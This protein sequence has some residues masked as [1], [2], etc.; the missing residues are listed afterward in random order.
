[1]NNNIYN[2]PFSDEFFRDCAA[3][4][5]YIKLDRM[6]DESWQRITSDKPLDWFFGN[7]NK[8]TS[9]QLALVKHQFRNED[10][11]WTADSHLE[12]NV[13]LRESRYTYLLT[14]EMNTDF[15][16]YFSDKYNLI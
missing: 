4:A 3:H 1:M 14:M 13:E 16:A 9:S 15:L 6:H 12:L 10:E 5:V 7:V 2:T 11:R 8:V